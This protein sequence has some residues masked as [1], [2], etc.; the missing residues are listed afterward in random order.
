MGRLSFHSRPDSTTVPELPTITTWVRSKRLHIACPLDIYFVV[1]IHWPCLR[2]LVSSHPSFPPPPPIF[3]QIRFAL[4]ALYGISLGVRNETKGL[5]GALFGLNVITFGTSATAMWRFVVARPG[6]IQY[7]ARPARRSFSVVPPPPSA[8][9]MVHQLA[10]RR[11]KELQIAAIRRRPERVRAHVAPVDR[12]VHDAAR[13]GGNIPRKGDI[14]RDHDGFFGGAAGDAGSGTR[15][16][17]RRVL[18]SSLFDVKSG[19][20]TFF[21]GEAGRG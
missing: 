2:R 19:N 11:R 14:G 17:S 18:I 4:G 3:G 20:L 9:D 1:P 8:D 16:K 21:S 6:E 15:A 10:Q 13:R 12:P 5:T 7:N